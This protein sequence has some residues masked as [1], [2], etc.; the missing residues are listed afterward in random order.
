MNRR[1][2][3]IRT[4]GTLT[5]VSVTPEALPRTAAGKLEEFSLGILRRGDV[6]FPWCVSGCAGPEISRDLHDLVETITE[7][8]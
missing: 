2:F 7:H 6:T 4:V 1:Q 5:A 8:D 3:F